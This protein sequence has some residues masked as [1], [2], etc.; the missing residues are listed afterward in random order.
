MKKLLT[1]AIVLLSLSQ[2]AFA[3]DNKYFNAGKMVAGGQAGI[4][5]LGFGFG[6][7][8]E[9][10]IT[11]KIGIQPAFI[12][13][14]YSAGTTDWYFNVI[15]VYGTYHFRP[16]VSFFDPEKM[17]SYGMAGVSFVSFGAESPGTDAET[18]SSFAFGSGAGSRYYFS[19]KLSV[20]GE[21]KYR[22]ASFKTDSF[23]LAIAWYSIAFGVTYAIN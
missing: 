4:S 9:Y 2:L 13:H 23:T 12:M 7:N 6:A 5:G 1:V 16:K 18:A 22:F 11:D 15:D 17:D 14:N 19:E 8:F 10:G 21:G 20:F 3:Q